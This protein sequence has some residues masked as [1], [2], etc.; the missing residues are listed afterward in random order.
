MQPAGEPLAAA[1]KP[2]KS[3][4]IGGF[5]RFGSGHGGPEVLEHAGPAGRILEHPPVGEPVEAV[6]GRAGSGG[7]R[8]GSAR[9]WPDRPRGRSPPDPAS[10]CPGSPAP[11]RCRRRPPS[12][13]A[14]GCC[15][16]SSGRP[17][18]PSSRAPT[19]GDADA[20][21][22][23]G[24]VV[25]RHRQLRLEE[26]LAFTRRLPELRDVVPL[27]VRLGEAGGVGDPRADELGRVLTSRLTSPPPQS[28]PTRSTGPSRA[29]TSSTSQAAY[30]S[31]VAPNP[32][33]HG[34]PK[35]GS[36][37]ATTSSRASSARRGSHTSAVSGTPW[38]R[39][40][41]MGATSGRGD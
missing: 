2:F 26:R 10:G 37:S 20:A 22:E 32:S 24:P 25:E 40:A 33:G 28:W 14:P 19:L 23:R 38:T 41:G 21:Q 8:L 34:H 3:P 13:T 7:G 15:R 30:S 17:P 29:A 1:W 27:E 18:R 9:G 36:R 39:T 11:T 6:H 5:E 16:P 35:P 31:L 12:G 4:E